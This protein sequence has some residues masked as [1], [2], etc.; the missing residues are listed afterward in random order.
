M[1]AGV[2]DVIRDRGRLLEE[3]IVNKQGEVVGSRF[4]ANPGIAQVAQYMALKCRLMIEF[5]MTPA[6]ATK[7]AASPEGARSDS[8]DEFTAGGDERG[9]ENSGGPVN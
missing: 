4:K 2:G 7:I 3:E 6:S 8:F 9:D 5:G 1:A